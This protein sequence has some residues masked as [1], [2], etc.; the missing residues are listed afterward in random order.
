MPVPGIIRRQAAEIGAVANKRSEIRIGAFPEAKMAPGG[1][2]EPDGELTGFFPQ[3][4]EAVRER[5]R[6][7]KGM[8]PDPMAVVFRIPVMEKRFRIHHGLKRG[9]FCQTG[10]ARGNT[11]GVLHDPETLPVAPAGAVHIC[12]K[13]HSLRHLP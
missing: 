13:C 4:R 1:C 11:P 2:D 9:D 6:W 7:I 12:Q 3:F 10:Q 8:L 5:Q